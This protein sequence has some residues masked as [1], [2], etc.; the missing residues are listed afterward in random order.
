MDATPTYIASDKDAWAYI[1]AIDFRLITDKLAAAHPL[2]SDSFIRRAIRAYKQFLFVSRKARQQGVRVTPHK[3]VDEV[4]HEHVLITKHYMADCNAIF[5]HYLHHHPGEVGKPSTQ[6]QT[7]FTDTNRLVRKYF[8]TNED[9]R[10]AL[11]DMPCTC[12]ACLAEYYTTQAAQ[13][14]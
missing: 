5:G 2:W 13:S 4:W 14:A 8:G 6:D 10:K 3:A 9:P 11:E 7:A 1:T 12:A